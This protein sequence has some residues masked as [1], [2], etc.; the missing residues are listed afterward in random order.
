M[1]N[2]TVC[3]LRFLYSKTLGKGWV[4]EHVHHPRGQKKLP[5]VLSVL[6]ARQLL[7]VVTNLKHRAILSTLYGTGIRL[8]ELCT[9]RV[10]DIDSQRMVIHVRLGKGAKDRL[11]MLSPRLL[12]LLRKYWKEGRPKG[13][14]FPGRAPAGSISPAAVQR[15]CKRSAQLAGISKDVHPHTLRHSFATHLLE[16]GIDLRRIQFLLGHGS[17]KTTSVYLHV[18]AEVVQ[19]T[20][21]P[22]DLLETKAK[23]VT[24]L[25]K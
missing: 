15:L 11:V 7:G 8:S 4:V 12:D 19:T 22:L 3:G 14:L 16:S 6:E 21:S 2:Q 18:A 25:K 5:T 9:L 13:W 1:F 17:L 20:P 24:P 23:T 10:S